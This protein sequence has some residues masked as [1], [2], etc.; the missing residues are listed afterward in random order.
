MRNSAS[1]LSAGTERMVTEFAGRSLLGKA[2]E[3]PDLVKQVVDKVKRDGL[4]PTARAVLT[5]LDQPIPLGYSCAGTILEVGAGVNELDA[6][7][8]VACAG[9]GYASHAEVVFVPRNLAVPVPPSVSDEDAA[10]VTVGAIAL[11]GL[12]VADVRL[13]ETVAVIGLGLLGQLTVQMLAA[14]GCRVIGIDLDPSKLALAQT[15]GASMT[16]LRSD[17]VEEAVSSFTGAIGVDAVIIAA[18]TDSNDP[19]ELA[20]A[21]ARERAAITVV[22]AVKMDVPRKVYYEKELQL[23]LSRSY[24]PGRY[25]PAYEEKGNDYPIGYVRWTERR[26]MEEFIRLVATGAVTPSRLTT[27]RFPVARAEDAYA[28]IGGDTGEAFTGVMLTY[29]DTHVV[30]QRTMTLSRR[31]PQSGR[32]GIGFIGAGNFA[33][34]ILLPRFAKRPESDLVMLTAA[35]GAT[36]KTA[37]EKFGFRACGTDTAALLANPDVHA[38]V[39]ATR[40]GSH[41]RLAEQA[42]RAGKSVFVEKPLALDEAQLQRV[43]EAQEASGGVLAV[44]FNRR[45]SPLATELRETMAAWGPIAVNYRINAGPIPASSWIHDAEEGGGRIIGEMCHFIDLL[46]FLTADT[47][48]EV[49]AAKLGGPGGANGDSVSVTMRFA[50][51]SVASLSYFST[52]DKSFS[53][54]RVEAFGSGG[55]AVLDDWQSLMITRGGKKRTRKLLA[56]DKGYDGEIAAFLDAARGGRAPIATAS[57]AATTRATFAI[58]ESLREGRAVAVPATP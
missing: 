40:H 13:G 5:R 42:L 33:R 39:I 15:M 3:R 12:R 19:T 2:R 17:A 46:Q 24:G 37:G 38:V 32:V 29:P 48:V 9:M 25:D 52:G 45:F 31:A 34:A 16:V 35:S 36:A 43:V 26:N 56:Q 10:Y 22:G 20:G 51:G 18:A 58:V 41:A 1:L 8:R 44:G 28:L 57:L 55:A 7:G 14:S 6:G 53:K 49:F 11:Q 50:G 23:R 30:P 4:M 54:E 27:H 47:P 21:I